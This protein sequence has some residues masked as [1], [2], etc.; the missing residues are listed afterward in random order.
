MKGYSYD[1]SLHNNTLVSAS[2]TEKEI[3]LDMRLQACPL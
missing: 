1:A 2:T 3:V